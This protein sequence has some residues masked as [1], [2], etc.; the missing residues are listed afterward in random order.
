M[1]TQDYYKILCVPENSSEADIKKAYRK[2][3]IECHPDHNPNDPKAEE[4][5]KEI[6]EAY[7][8]L[9]DPLKR[10]EYDRFR[11]GFYA[12]A[13][14]SSQFRYSQQDIFESMFQQAFGRDIFAELNKEF[15]RSGYRS[16]TPF[17]EAIFFGGAAGSLGRLLTMIPG[18][19]GKLGYVLRLVQMV[20]ASALALN[21]AMKNSNTQ[22][23][24]GKPAS[25][26]LDSIKGVL[27]LSQNADL[28]IEMAISISP[29]EALD[30]TKKKITYKAGDMTEKLY[31]TIPPGITSGDKLRLKERG[32][33]KNSQRGDLIIHI[34]VK[35]S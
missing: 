14:S 4:K 13:D 28:N 31:V 33:K 17:F 24:A 8:V 21:R 1:K 20:G 7:G 29:G 23:D 30:G 25:S 10:R 19:L 15:S 3:A 22:T 2:L 18:P 26:L 12:G 32:S 5:F 35:P 11:S 27:G 16:G 34:E 9:M 6:T